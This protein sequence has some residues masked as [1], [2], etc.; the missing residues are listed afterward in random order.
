MLLLLPLLPGHLLLP[1]PWLLRRL[2]AGSLLLSHLSL[3][4]P[5]LLYRRLLLWLQA[6]AVRRGL[7][8]I[9]SGRHL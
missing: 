6:R 9:C 5:W 1:P 8:R 7:H 3:L 2:L 4:P